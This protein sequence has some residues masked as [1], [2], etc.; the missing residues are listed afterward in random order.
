MSLCRVK[1]LRLP[2]RQRYD[3][4]ALQKYR[5]LPRPLHYRRA[6]QFSARQQA[7]ERDAV[8]PV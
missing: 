2:T 8:A 7:D 4:N 3:M 5:A 6:Y 1:A